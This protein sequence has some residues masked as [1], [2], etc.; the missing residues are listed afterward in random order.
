MVFIILGELI[1]EETDALGNRDI[2]PGQCGH[3]KYNGIKLGSV[4]KY[5]PTN[6]LLYTRNRRLIK[7]RIGDFAY[8]KLLPFLVDEPNVDEV[9]MNI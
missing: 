7:L 9:I 2:E 8:N 3:F 1:L 5:D 6:K 4:Y